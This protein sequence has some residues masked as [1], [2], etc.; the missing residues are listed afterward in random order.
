[1]WDRLNWNQDFFGDDKSGL[2]AARLLGVALVFALSLLLAS[3]MPR[4][5]VAP[6]MEELL[7]FGAIG[8]AVHAVFLR[9]KLSENHVTGW[10]QAA[11][12]L[13]GSQLFGFLVDHQAAMAALADMTAKAGGAA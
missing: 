9:E 2:N 5:L 13:L 4:A 7:Y 12:L 6:V 8:A 10:D 1:M 11:L 3:F